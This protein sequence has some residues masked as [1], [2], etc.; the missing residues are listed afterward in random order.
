MVSIFSSIFYHNNFSILK[1]NFHKMFLYL[2][3]EKM[4][5]KNKNLINIC[6]ALDNNI[7]YL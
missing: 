1:K 3:D 5:L 4:N 2:E 7:F 6:M